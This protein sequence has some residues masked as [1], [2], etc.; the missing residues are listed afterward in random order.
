MA[1][2]TG[3]GD[4]MSGRKPPQLSR[5]DNTEKTDAEK[6]IRGY[7]LGSV[8]SALHKEVRRGGLES[9][10]YWGLILYEAAPQYASKRALVTARADIGFGER[11]VVTKAC[12]M[13][14]AWKGSKERSWDVS[15]QLG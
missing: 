7:P 10:V 3:M 4:R 14:T 11:D 8:A 2:A 1:R 12:T 13:A 5:R 6:L 15:P 9:A